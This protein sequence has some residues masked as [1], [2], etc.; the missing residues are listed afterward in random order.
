MILLPCWMCAVTA[1]QLIYNAVE[2]KKRSLLQ[3]RAMGNKDN[4]QLT[5]M[6]W[7]LF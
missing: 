6:P 1:S 5:R 4:M 2:Y 7:I 3:I